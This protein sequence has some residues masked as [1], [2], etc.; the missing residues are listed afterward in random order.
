MARTSRMAATPIQGRVDR[1][2]LLRGTALQAAVGLAFA[3]PGA[4][5]VRPAAAQPAPNARP[6]GGQVVAGAAAIGN[7]A[8]TTTV[9]QS[10]ARAA[11]DWRSFDVGRNQ[12]VTFQQPGSTSVTLNRVTGPDPSAIAG[13]ISANG[14]VVLVNPSGVIFHQGA[15]V[16]AQSVVVSA[17]GISNQNF[18]A[19][20]MVFDQAARSGARIE[21]RGAITVREAGLAALVAPSVA[22]SGVITARL[23]RVVLAGAAA[24]T[25]DMYGDGL[26]AIDVTKQVRQ[27]PSGPDGKVATALVTN[28]GTI[29]ADGGTVLLTARAADG[30]VQDL[31]RAGGAIHANT[32][33][34]Q[35]GR[36]EIAGTG[37]SVVIEGRVAADGRVPGA[38][39]G[40]IAVAGSG[41]TVLAPTARVTANG[42]AGGGTVALGT[43][44]ARAT[45][46]GPAPAGTSVRTAVAAGARVSADATRAG[47]GGRVTVLS[48]RSTSVDG[49]VGAR[50]G[51]ASG[52]G[53]T[54]ELSGEAG[55]RLTGR[56]DTSAP[57]GALGT[58][59]LDPRDL[60]I[61]ATPT[62]TN[63]TPANGVDP[64]L[65]AGA[66]G[67][68]ADAYVTPAQVQGLTG[69]V[70]LQATRD[71]T[72]G[73][74]ITYA[75]GPNLALEAG[76]NLTV[77]AGVT[78]AVP[79]FS[80]R[81]SST[82]SLLTLTA[83]A[84]GISGRDPA[85]TL[86]VLGN[87]S[88]SGLAL[89]AGTGGIAL[90]GTIQAGQGLSVSTT[91]ALT[92][93]GGAVIGGDLTGRAASVS[94]PS[95]GNA[96][97]SV[98]QRQLFQVTGASGDFLLVNSAP[99]TIGGSNSVAETSGGIFLQPGRTATLVADTLSI[100]KSDGSPNVSAPGGL[101]V[102]APYTPGGGILL[103]N[104]AKLDAQT[105]QFG[106]LDGNGVP[107]AG[108]IALGQAGETIDLRAI[109]L[110]NLVLLST[111]PV[112][113]DGAL[114]VPGTVSGQAGSLDLPNGGNAIPGLAG[115]TTTAGNVALHT[116]T[117][118][119]VSGKV[120]A[121]DGAGGVALSSS[122]LVPGSPGTSMLLTGDIAGRTV[123]LN[124][125]TGSAP[126]A[127]DGGITQAGGTVTASTLT[128]A[129]GF[130]NLARANQIGALGDFAT[131]GGL[132]VSNGGA[133]SIT[134]AVSSVNGA[135]TLNA[136]GLTQAASSSISTAE[137]D[138]S[139]SGDT[140]LNSRNNAVSGMGSFFQRAGD[141]TLV[142]SSPRLSFGGNAGTLT[143]ASGSFTFVADGVG[144]VGEPAGATA[145]TAPSGA[146]TFA[147][148]SAS[149]RIELI[150]ATAADPASLS[151]S[152][153]LL[154]R[155]TAVRLGLGNADSTGPI[156]IANA[157]ETVDLTGHAGTL[158]LRTTGTVTEGVSPGGQDGGGRLGLTV[159]NLTGS[160]G[161]LALNAP[162]NAIVTVGVGDDT[163]SGLAGLAAAGSLGVQS[164]LS[165]TVANTVS[166][167]SPSGTLSIRSA[168]ALQSTGTVSGGSVT[169]GA[170]GGT[171]SQVA[172]T[173]TAAGT[174]TLLA[175]GQA[176]V[177]TDGTITAGT[178]AGSAASMALGSADNR[179][180]NLG[181]VTAAGAFALT[182]GQSLSVSG[183]VS[184]ASA[185]LAVAGDLALAGTITAPGLLSLSAT[186]TITQPGGT[187]QAGTLTGSAAGASF[188][189]AGNQ[190]PVL[191]GFNSGGDFLLA[192]AAA[193]TVAGPVSA[194][195]GGTLAIRNDAPGFARGG[196]LS[197]PGG[198][199]AL[200]EYTAGQ[201]I[202]L[203][204][205]GGLG[206]DP[207]VTASTLVVGSATGGPVVVAGAFN[208]L[209]V[210]VLDLRSGGAI[211]ETGAGALRVGTL[212]G[213]G[214]SAKLGGANQIGTL[215]RFTAPG[216]LALTDAQPLAVAGPVTAGSVALLVSGDLTLSGTV[217]AA[218]TLG[219]SVKGA[220]TQPGGTVAAGTL[221]GDAD[222]ASLGAAGNT[223]AT[224]GAFGTGGS[225]AL[226]S[227]RSLTVAGPVSAASASLSATGDLA[228]V[229]TVSTPGAL[230]L[231][232]TGAITQPGGT[233]A[234]GTLTGSAAS[235][236]LGQGNAVGTLGAFATT[237]AFA[238]TDARPLAVAGPVAA[239]SA[240]LAVTGDLSL[241]G[242]VTTPGTLSLAA[243]GAIT[244]PAGSITAGALAGTAASA[245][246]DRTDNS[247]ASLAGFTAAGGFTLTDGRSL[248]ITGPVGS[249]AVRLTARGDLALNSSVTGGTVVLD[250]T[251]AITEGP[252]GR[253]AASTLSGNGASAAL[254]GGNRVGTL[255]AFTTAGGLAFNNGQAL[256]VAG[257]VGDR[258]SVGIAADGPLDVSGAVAAPSVALRSSGSITQ[259][260]A[261]A[262]TADA[263]TLAANGPVSLAGSIQAGTLAVAT[264]GALAQTGGSLAV[265][266]LTGTAGSIDIGRAGGA[267]IS[268][269]AD[270]AAGSTAVVVDQG[271]LRVSGT[272]G[273]PSLALTAT[274]VLTLDGGTLRID[275]APAV[276]GSTLAVRPGIDG[277]SALRQTGTTII[278][279]LSG[280]LAT[281]RLDLPASGG[282]LA[283]S[284]LRAPSADL[285][286]GLG[287]GTAQ[288]NLVVN[289]LTLVGAGGRATL[290][291]QALGR[292]D[293]TAAQ[294]ARI[295]PRVDI[296]YTLNGCTV[297]AVSCSVVRASITTLQPAAAIAS[298][299]RPDVLALDVLGLSVTRDRDDPTLL[300]P[301]ISDRDY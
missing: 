68:A 70:R 118:L 131:Y 40:S 132:T 223:I 147:P 11:I 168:R 105:L 244:Q 81:G 93:T 139:S 177:Q 135:V 13:R 228:M 218:G 268:G 208:L 221:T 217:A 95:R 270:L 162:A 207:P 279:P 251:G 173:I 298:L 123:S 250:V 153:S 18:M 69:N 4:M 130:L 283:L 96:L 137:L 107:T 164:A 242:T 144:L 193:L 136:P 64:N 214:A 291:G 125:L 56:A 66:G 30:V 264:P 110:T 8:T 32:A 88:A 57:H 220:I 87:V 245:A 53:G 102:I 83:A 276:A 55:F 247:V 158:Q 253:I 224:L 103:T 211:T 49:T 85:G 99:L 152:Q 187:L 219:L 141:F 161:S 278:V 178:L 77:N 166:A 154:P 274:G 35:V 254:T 282:T 252:G 129:G 48:T 185:S 201:G 41:A 271:P 294:L 210:P 174:L 120:I 97:D 259:A 265:G 163:G 192:D 9:S 238:L 248:A 112:T 237:G 267:R 89:S 172:G 200:A 175:P 31:V 29:A 269:I 115:L 257:P 111:G 44:L 233:A 92:Q 1:R 6:Q 159:A 155:I 262:V 236:V 255:G 273:S 296:G 114:R 277:T 148:F 209:A 27:A 293:A 82:P 71:L 284:N 101:I 202:T 122:G 195:K 199:V 86:Q 47:N 80:I 301:N 183:P 43:T 126:A 50:G 91:G 145:V 17:A 22:N 190:V 260:A 299:L 119:T 197:A 227:G 90:S 213:Q 170:G 67:T 215:G 52:N 134:G 226:A 196:S 59:V 21:N 225:F 116:S 143:A 216:G 24:H 128:G 191:S 25:L 133:L 94:L 60:T 179:V 156:N 165:L 222:S 10:S 180:G 249:N 292:T 100:V 275:G 45:G 272:V 26:V 84:P 231:S 198:T 74:D 206:S 121:I 240:S 182:D 256:S 61:T 205:G 104:G 34:G 160:A 12:A 98:G 51:Q 289:N 16:N 42:W 290:T 181:G 3:V 28:T 151:V 167:N 5:P 19:G 286:L 138:G 146:V 246:I 140:V 189:Q 149:R 33:G 281:L 63:L 184:A 194:G 124:S 62:G 108:S 38:T 295:E 7:T 127:S 258:Q 280:R 266:T 176:V 241:A 235:A 65:A 113:Q 75:S 204:G 287:S 73:S 188:G 239:A 203:A 229:G 78:I 232:A 288:G 46:S 150:G 230:L 186:G 39:G 14:Q 23:G 58:I 76:R 234:A 261:S 297:A 169:L 15:Q 212:V 106:L 2:H 36:I 142:T 285:V 263:L 54:V 79:A 157:N 171:L 300:L 243:T 20:R 117:G 72:V 109:G 37:G